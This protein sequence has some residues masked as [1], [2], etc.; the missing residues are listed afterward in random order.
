MLKMLLQLF[1][2]N[3]KRKIVSDETANVQK[4]KLLLQGSIDGR[5]N[6]LLKISRRKKPELN[7]FKKIK[8]EHLLRIETF[9]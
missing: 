1:K 5:S 4:K 3:L 9:K 7:D 2:V 8:H 6:N